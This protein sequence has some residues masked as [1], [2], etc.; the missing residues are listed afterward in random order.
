ME[1]EVQLYLDDAVEKMQKALTHLEEELGRVRAGKAT[2]SLLDGITVDYYGTMTPLSQVSNINTPDARTIAVQPWEKSMIEPIEKAIMAANIGLMPINNGE[3]IRINI[4]ALTEERRKQ[5]VKQIKNMGEN[6][7]ISIRNA[8]RDA[9]DAFKKMKKEGLSEDQ[10]KD[11]EAQ[12]QEQT[13]KY[14]EEVDKLLETK[15]NDIMTI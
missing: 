12:V 3:L 13:N 7:R 4:P 2:T 11:A 1:E 5:L 10:E 8:R 15:E 6:T 14:I 9:N